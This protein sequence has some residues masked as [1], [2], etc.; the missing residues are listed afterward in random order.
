MKPLLVATAA[1]SFLIVGASA[2]AADMPVAP[3]RPLPIFNWTSCFAG[4]HGGAGSANKDI[5]DPVQLVQD[6]L[7][8]G[9]FT[10]GPTTLN[11]RPNGYLVGGQFGC[12]YQPLGANW[13]VGFEGAVS[14][15]KIDSTGI[16]GLPLGDP[17]DVASVRAR[18]DFLASGTFRFGYAWDNLLLYVKGGAGAASDNFIVAGVF[19]AITN[20][21][22]FNFTGLDLRIGWTA[23]AGVEWAFWQNWSAKLEYEYYGFGTKSVLLTDSNL[24]LS[25]PVNVTQNVQTVKL[26][27]NVRMWSSDW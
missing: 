7:L 3:L 25:A 11:L 22:P 20:P 19:T 5:T 18:I 13:V 4:V 27:L 21:T 2:F 15:G 8:G 23:G 26:G 6:Q 12:D 10:V 24:A 14:G 9:P 16:V 17:G 1:T